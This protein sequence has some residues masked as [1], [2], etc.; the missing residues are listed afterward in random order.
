MALKPKYKM[1]QIKALIKNATTALLVKL[2]LQRPMAA[3]TAAS[4]NKLAATTVRFLNDKMAFITISSCPDKTPINRRN[5][6]FRLSSAFSEKH[7]LDRFENDHKIERQALV[8]DVIE[9]VL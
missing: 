3:N 9:V 2:L 6:V 1:R 7:G 8:L 4:K 5:P